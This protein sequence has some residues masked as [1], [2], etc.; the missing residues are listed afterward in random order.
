MATEP[1]CQDL[2]FLVHDCLAKHM[3]ESAAFYADK[4]VTV[5]DGAPGDV[6]VLA[7][8]LYMGR[9]WRRALALLRSAGLVEADVRGRY[10]AARC[11]AEVRE[12]E[13]CLLVLGGWDDTDANTMDVQEAGPGAD[14]GRAVSYGAAMC[15]LRGRAYAGLDNRARAAAWFRAALRADPFCHEAFQVLVEG[16]MLT[17]AEE[18]ELRDSLRFRPQD[19]WLQLLC[20]AKCKKYDQH[21]TMDATLDCLEAPV[22]PGEYA[23]DDGAYAHATPAQQIPATRPHSAQDSDGVRTCAMSK[24]STSSDGG[25]SVKCFSGAGSFV[26]VNA[27]GDR[28]PDT[29]Q[30]AA[31]PNTVTSG[32]EGAA[33]VARQGCGL[34]GNLDVAV[35]RA[36][37]LFHQ[38]SYQEAFALTSALLERN[39]YALEAMP[40]HLTASLELR[41]KNELFLRG[42]RLAEEYPDRA[43][44]WFAVGCYYLCAEQ[45]ESARRFFGKATAL[46]A[47]FAPAWLGFGHAF[48]AQDESDQ[49]MA[50]YRTAARLFPGLHLPLVGMGMEYARMNNAA[51]AEQLLLAAHRT[52]PLDP[53]ACHELGCLAFRARQLPAAERWLMMALKR[54]PGRMTAVWEPTL[55]NLGHVFRK[56]RRWADAVGAFQQALGLCPGQPGT[57][58]ALGYTHHLQ[59]DLEAA[60]EDYHKALGLRPEDTFTAEMLTEALKE[61]AEAEDS[62][63]L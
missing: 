18:A 46:D 39:P 6:Y 36:E 38:G 61:A 60:I 1:L 3:Y 7:Q 59:G 5:S 12:W 14:L 29:G 53:L 43:A 11:L 55:V 30:A 21:A 35:C 20:S 42:H 8:A 37:W 26:G 32:A 52:C 25:G 63:A 56:Q 16:H 19:R 45:H 4:L 17:S 58:A 40:V 57:Y 34:A 22:Q 15:L 50:A 13:E 23:Q 44:A 10:L 54:V 24:A 62:A 28:R 48:A 41:K 49:A 9:Q 51:L 31:H 33:D 27:F 47:S 2:R